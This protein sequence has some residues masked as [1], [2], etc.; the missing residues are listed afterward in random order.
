[1]K[2]RLL[3]LI[4]CL[5]GILFSQ[6]QQIIDLESGLLSTMIKSTMPTRHVEEVEDGYIVNYTFTNAVIQNDKQFP[7]TIFW[8][9]EGF[10]MN[11]TSGEPCTLRREDSFAIPDGCSAKVEVMDSVCRYFKYELTPARLP[12]F[13][14][15]SDDYSQ[16]NVVEIKQY[17]GYKPTTLVSMLGTQAYRGHGMCSVAI[18]PMQYDHKGKTIRAYTS[19]TYRITF[20][21]TSTDA[22]IRGEELSVDD[23]FI[24]NNIIGGE[25]F[26]SV[27][28]RSTDVARQDVK[29][30]LIISTSTYSSAAKRFAEWKRLMGFNTHVNIR[31]DW[32]ETMVKNVVD[33]AYE[34]M[35][36]L[37]YLLI[38]GDHEDVPAKQLT[39]YVTDF[40]YGCMDDDYVQDVY[41]GRLSVSTLEE[42]N[43]VV[44]KIINYERNPPTN[45]SFYE[46]ALH[47]A[48]FQD[49]NRDNFA[50]RRFAQ[51]SEDVR[52]YVM[53]KGKSVQR[54]YYTP[55]NVTP[56]FW[57][58]PSYSC[59]ES[60]PEELKK[61]EFAWNGNFSDINNAIN[62]GVLY[63]LYRGHGYD[64]GW[65]YPNYPKYRLQGL[66]NNNL[67]PIVFSMTCET[68]MFNENCFAEAFL[69][70]N[71]GG[72]VAI[73]GATEKS[74]SGYND[75]LVAGMFDAIWPTPGLSI[76]IPYRNDPIS[77][78]PAPT[79]TLGQI[80]QQGMARVVETYG[81]T[82][83]TTKCTKELFHC[84]GD[85]SMKIFT[86]PPTAFTDVSI[87]RS[88][89]EITVN[90]GAGE[91]GRIT[92]YDPV[93]GM[94]QSYIGSNATV[95][96][97]N[98]E[99]AI[100]CVSAHNR[101]PFIQSPDIMYIQNTN[102]T[103][104]QNE[105]HNII[106]VGNHVTSAIDTGDVTISDANVTL[107][108][109]KVILD[110]GTFISE[111]SN[112][113]IINP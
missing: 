14:S 84:F 47:C 53:A 71:N 88:E 70:N 62:D 36:A 56:L 109:G 58:T 76:R 98:P 87:S 8:K 11:Q 2:R 1:M 16:D 113:K 90:L 5:Q 54:V 27:N 9:V 101:V 103:G 72:C 93:S 40:Y 102:I 59:G 50:D 107:R 63:V 83:S 57:N 6:A 4:L 61:P 73:Y 99:D 105:T 13:E 79:Y 110:A 96:S 44:D 92:V 80:L 108:A 22:K 82:N 29:D 67:L 55:S 21:P 65:A 38:I 31:D 19:I 95:N 52:T 39:Q 33:D 43:I 30:Y 49:N 25:R 97:S 17:E 46:N 51:T 106:K 24:N 64:T 75:V 81:S 28:T 42:A 7:S 15:S 91:S 68:G 32:T 45:R 20:V 86:D 10:G 48:Y 111:G 89:N 69:R 34:D 112:F 37:Y 77:R 94:V 66:F 60:I 85:P 100:V 3:V 41:C 18:S 78:A 104:T 12:Q 26:I 23:N 35:P 74:F